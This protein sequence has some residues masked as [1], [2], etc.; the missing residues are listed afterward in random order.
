MR[1]LTWL[2]LTIGKIRRGVIHRMAAGG[3]GSSQVWALMSRLNSLYSLWPLATDHHLK[4]QEILH[5]LLQKCCLCSNN[6]MALLTTGMRNSK[7]LERNRVIFT[8]C[9][10]YSVAGFGTNSLRSLKQTTFI[11]NQSLCHMRFM[12]LRWP[13]TQD[14]KILQYSHGCYNIIV[15]QGR[16]W[17]RV[18]KLFFLAKLVCQKYVGWNCT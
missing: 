14:L 5:T 9:V 18:E 10:C 13:Q 11:Q 7:R 2:Y 1:W 4:N 8:V 17:F 3:H 12:T 16:L 15:S 6:M